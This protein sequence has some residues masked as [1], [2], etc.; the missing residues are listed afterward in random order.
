VVVGIRTEVADLSDQELVA[1]LRKSNLVELAVRL[2]LPI[3]KRI[4]GG[5]T[6]C[7]FHQDRKPSMSLYQSKSG[8]WLF[9]CFSCKEQ[10]DVFDLV[11]KV[12]NCDFPSALEK[13]ALLVGEPLPRRTK[14][15]SVTELS[16]VEVAQQFYANQSSEEKKK[17]IA[18]GK[19]RSFK[20]VTI[21]KFSINVARN[22]K[23]ST[24]VREP[25]EVA[26]LRDAELIYR[27][28]FATSQQPELEL[29]VPYRDAM[30]GERV[31]FPIRD[32]NGKTLGFIGRAVQVDA[33]PKYQFTR[34]FPKS[35]SLFG[36]D[37]ARKSMRAKVSAS[38][39]QSKQRQFVLYV[40][41]GATDVLRLHDLGLDAVAVLGSDL[42]ADQIGLIE[43][44]A[45]EVID[46]SG[47]LTLRLFFDG[48]E[49]GFSATRLAL[50][51]LLQYQSQEVLFAVEIVAA[52]DATHPYHG[53]DPDEWLRDANKRNAKEQIDASVFSCGQF[54]MAYG[55]SCEVNA[56]NARWQSLAM[57]QRYAAMRR[58]DNLLPKDQWK[59]VFETL[60][61]DL[62]STTHS[63]AGD[64]TEPGSWQARLAA[65]LSRNGMQSQ[66]RGNALPDEL[67]S[68]STKLIHAIQIANAFSQRREFPVDSRSWDRLLAAS[69][70]V[71]SYLQ[72]LLRQ[73]TGD[74]N[75][76]PFLGMHVPK[77][78]GGFRLKA[79]PCPEQ[80]SIQQYLLNEL[81]G[82]SIFSQDFIE[83]IPAVRYD[84][85][86]LRS[87]AGSRLH[88]E[89]VSCFSYQIDMAIVRGE[90]PPGNEGI[91]RPYTECWTDFVDFLSRKVQAS[92][93]ELFDERPFY[94]AR[95]DVRAYYDTLKREPVDRI[96]FTPL[97]EAI[98]T[99]DEPLSFAP[100]FRPDI[101]DATE[102]T[103]AFIDQICHQS[104]GYT[105]FDPNTGVVTQHKDGA[106]VGMPQ[107]PSLSA[108]IG[109]IA[110]FNLDQSVQDAIESANSKAVYARYVD[111]MV[112]ITR[113]KSE[114][115]KLRGIV[116]KELGL[117]GLELSPK[118]EPLPSMN[119]VQVQNWLTAN[120]GLANVSGVVQTPPIVGQPIGDDGCIDR[121]S[122]LVRLHDP[123]LLNPSTSSSILLDVVRGVLTC[124]DVRFSDQ[125]HTAELIWTLIAGQ[126]RSNRIGSD[127]IDG[128]ADK[129]KQL[130]SQSLDDSVSLQ[131]MEKWSVLAA[132][133]G[134]DSLLSRRNFKSDQFDD[135][136]QHQ[137]Y[138]MRQAIANAVAGGL[139]Q[140]LLSQVA[141]K[142][143]SLNHILAVHELNLIYRAL[144]LTSAKNPSP[145]LDRVSRIASE[146]GRST[147]VT[148]H[149]VSIAALQNG[150]GAIGT[151]ASVSRGETEPHILFHEAI[152]RLSTLY[153][154]TGI[155]PLLPMVDS[156]KD[157]YSQDSTSILSNVL[158]SWL[159]NEVSEIEE[160]LATRSLS[161][162]LNVVN[163]ASIRLINGRD[164]LLSRA[165]RYTNDEP[166]TWLP[167]LPT[168]D[169]Y[170]FVGH[171][172]ANFVAVPVAGFLA[173][174]NENDTVDEWDLR[175]QG[176]WNSSSSQ[177]AP[178]YRLGSAS[179][180]LLITTTSDTSD[181]STDLPRWIADSFEF[182]V[183]Q[184]ADGKECPPT[185]LNLL[186]TL[187][188]ESTDLVESAVTGVLGFSAPSHTF[189]AQAF[190]RSSNQSLIPKAVYANGA[191]YWRAGIAIAD[192]LGIIDE[193]FYD[194]LKS[195]V[196]PTFSDKVDPESS[197]R[198]WAMTK[199]ILFS[200]Q[201]LCGRT[202]NSS[203]VRESA[204]VPKSL[205]RVLDRLRSFPA[206]ALDANG[207]QGLAVVLASVFETR[208]AAARF[209]NYGDQEWQQKSGAAASI[210]ARIARRVIYNDKQLATR[211]PRAT[212]DRIV[213]R[214]SVAAWLSFATRIH[215]LQE[216]IGDDKA[217]L[218]TPLLGY[219][220]GLAITGLGDLLRCLTLETI[221]ADKNLHEQIASLNPSSVSLADWCLDGF[222][223]F[224][225]LNSETST[226]DRV[227]TEVE[228][229]L[230]SLK[231]GLAYD[232]RHQSKDLGRITPLGWAVLVGVATGFL[233]SDLKLSFLRP[234]STDPKFTQLFREVCSFLT[235]SAR[236]ET[237]DNEDADDPWSGLDKLLD[238]GCLSRVAQFAHELERFG[239]A[240][241][242]RVSNLRSSNR[243]RMEPTEFES[244]SVEA[245]NRTWQV[246]LDESIHEIEP[247]RIAV[248]STANEL[249]NAR[250]ENVR[251][252]E[253]SG[254]A[255][256]TYFW[257][258]TRF[259]GELIC[260]HVAKPG[261]ADLA[262]FHLFPQ[263]VVKNEENIS[264]GDDHS[265][266]SLKG[267]DTGV[268]SPDNDSTNASDP[269]Q[270][271]R[272][273]FNQIASRTPDRNDWQKLRELQ[274]QSWRVRRKS[275]DS[276]Y[277]R[278][279]LVQWQVE[280][281]GSYRHP[282]YECR[283]QEL[284]ELL[285]EGVKN[286]T[287][288]IEAVSY[289][290]HRRRRL[291]TEVLKACKA[292]GVEM[293]LLP[294]YSTRPET[295]N[296][297]LQ[298]LQRENIS[299]TVWAG[300]FRFPPFYPSNPAAWTHPLRE[301]SSVLPIIESE[302]G[303]LTSSFA[304]VKVRL[305]KYPSVAYGEIFNPDT[306]SLKEM[307]DSSTQVME[308][309]CSEIFL[310]SSPTNLIGLWKS[311][312]D[313][314]QKFG[315][316][317]KEERDAIDHV[318]GDMKAFARY[319]TMCRETGLRRSILFVPAMTPR[320]VDYAVLGQAS[321]LAAGLTTVFCND[322]GVHSHG[323]SC[324]IG[325]NGWDRETRETPGLLGPGPYHGVEPGFY[326]PFDAGRGWL[327][328]KEQALLIADVDPLYQAEGKPRPQSLMPPLN[329]IAHLPILEVGSLDAGYSGK[330]GR[331]VK[332]RPPDAN[333]LAKLEWPDSNFWTS[334]SIAN[335]S[336]RKYVISTL[337]ALI[338][339]HVCQSK[340]LPNTSYDVSHERLS[341][342]LR[343]LAFA[344]PE[345]SD[346][347]EKRA[348]A[349]ASH[350]AA[351]PMPYPP[352]VALDWLYV[353]VAE[354]DPADTK[355]LVPP[356]TFSPSDQLL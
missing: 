261:I 107:G 307:T 16:G 294:E 207:Y 189:D 168:D 270:S 22:Q 245:P 64:A 37:V 84:G 141:T 153:D 284:I 118:V 149:V 125:C 291:L 264:A 76:E 116:Q 232:N 265:I 70:V 114:L 349:Y 102:R 259:D 96:L 158:V 331:T 152:A 154:N 108:Y 343:A 233:R 320:T 33:Q 313:L 183:N 229:L 17:L 335:I 344:A 200:L 334:Q 288:V 278:I 187:K 228:A 94:V 241:G 318:L 86:I 68:E 316:P 81:L 78:S 355:I 216:Q 340:V 325:Q 272:A 83:R 213:R 282:V 42:S 159:P 8:D 348:N 290:E 239:E 277:K 329:L 24:S 248:A 120:R 2:G 176:D 260:V 328:Q 11:R 235:P 293:L 212:T 285:P 13:V 246:S 333:K 322:S 208:F 347:L 161:V 39:E 262:G 93:D 18:W 97:L 40:V 77:Q 173:S 296:W 256:R 171:S 65:Y 269:I 98:K 237:P 170:G 66:S 274:N 48:D 124:P 144:S 178:F 209:D 6:N 85:G 267:E 356:V 129:F 337:L 123:E 199:L 195:I 165:L 308:L 95:L 162:F 240:L 299:L 74:R 112:L 210:L 71:T 287:S 254:N 3:I 110:L 80:L 113:S 117:I 314:C 46:D 121:R 47:S 55:L 301:W 302:S 99:L 253:S 177:T 279:A 202:P 251:S 1:R 89:A 27:P 119:A 317:P 219:C 243:F 91:F 179:Y 75:I 21:S 111:D 242:L 126:I 131:E 51:K 90:K 100:S 205:R 164:F 303:G 214:R 7:L 9:K 38:S 197:D 139:V 247:W 147:N 163:R 273:T 321:Y 67:E 14:K 82:A 222:E 298:R 146:Y 230:V 60:G 338:S 167:C 166:T 182:L 319:T 244:D 271:E 305:K 327:G 315:N 175:P 160:R 23:L 323:Q 252:T 127:D 5:T 62:F 281:F 326:R 30:V 122:A 101:N 220:N 352:P 215:K 181:F 286:H 221:A 249:R 140:R 258:E 300:T 339:E 29:D 306:D 283:E 106:N 196:R 238:K 292:F 15:A 225:Y 351:N 41:E 109:T 266:Q 103:R 53:H 148:R 156:I 224:T 137:S 61:S 231:R 184:S 310:A 289:V 297:L 58:I 155:D 128:I 234:E 79:I 312:D 324:F 295:V 115:D 309:I 133:H 172:S 31:I 211:L 350:H 174:L 105:Y 142:E 26:A 193:V 169:I 73:R 226:T 336:N 204:E 44:L 25:V 192:A 130:W 50:S 59:R 88:R 346:W 180:K 185:A 20:L 45:R 217:A 56:V 134:L 188:S 223:L 263:S 304:K 198:Q 143:S 311:W 4:N 63:T 145:V 201:R 138:A 203:Y 250:A 268:T 206:S 135:D 341:G 43:R 275:D 280:E 69:N 330:T 12:D 218:Q 57:T 345:N 257:T 104:F 136:Q 255:N 54:L 191:R 36:L 52:S 132:V 227:K 87:T 10:G 332:L 194:P 190:V 72:D 354:G 157:A 32:W 151:L 92:D 35:Q 342:L 276:H 28:R 150:F 49:A 186:T 353:D 236:E 34:H 19:E